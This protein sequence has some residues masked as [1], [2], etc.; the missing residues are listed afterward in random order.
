METFLVRARQRWKL[1]LGCWVIIVAGVA[2]LAN[3][4]EILKDGA[5]SEWRWWLYV[6][7]PPLVL[8]VG[9]WMSATIQC[10]SCGE[11]LFWQAIAARSVHGG[12]GSLLTLENCP[13]CGSDGSSDWDGT[14]AFRRSSNSRASM[15]GLDDRNDS[16]P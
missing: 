11:K 14:A 12:L 13:A 4:R 16:P 8:G 9:A 1:W 5:T 2:M 15:L 6:A 7:L 3:L 10:P